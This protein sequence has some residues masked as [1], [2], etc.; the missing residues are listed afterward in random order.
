MNFN[1]KIEQ[2]NIIH[3]NKYDYSK[4]KYINSHSKSTIICPI[5]GDFEQVWSAHFHNKAGCPKCAIRKQCLPSTKEIFVKKAIKIHDNFYSYNNTIYIK[6]NVKVEIIC[7]IHGSFWQTPSH[8]INRKH[9]CPKCKSVK[10]G[11]RCRKSLELFIKEANL[12]H[13]NYYIYDEVNYVDSNIKI[14][15][16]CPI[17]GEFEQTPGS[18]LSGC[19][20]KFCALDSNG[21]TTKDRFK[22]RCKSNKGI[23]YIIKCFNDIE[24][25]YK[26]GL[27]SKSIKQRYSNSYH[28]PYKYETIQE[29]VDDPDNLWELEYF[30]KYYIKQNNLHYIPKI[31]FGGHLSECYLI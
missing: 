29:I 3:K 8:H 19:G 14:K 27:T 15:I 2:A 18:H 4:F 12:K 10:Q 7:P 23:F 28:M 16:I 31:K 11:N 25:F 26:L 9:G 1:D 17:H 21:W 22:Q 13:N 24:M 20:C 6:S 30:L 5:H